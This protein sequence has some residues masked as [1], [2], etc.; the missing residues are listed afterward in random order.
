MKQAVQSHE[1]QFLSKS[2][3]V[4]VTE[5]MWRNKNSATPVSTQ[6]ALETQRDIDVERF[7]NNK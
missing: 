6:K 4:Q 2:G 7:L 3:W 1:V 5:N